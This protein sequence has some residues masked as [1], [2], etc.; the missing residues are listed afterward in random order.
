M[1]TTIAL[2]YGNVLARPASGNWFLPADLPRILGLGNMMKM[3]SGA[4][5][6]QGNMEKAKAYLDENH[7]LHTVEEEFA[8]FTRFYRIAFGGV[9]MKGLDNISEALARHAVYS[10]DKAVFYGDAQ[11]GIRA[12][13]ERWRV[14]V[15][16]DTWP[17]L[18]NT[19]KAAGIAPLLDGMVMSC[20][21]GH[22]K[23]DNGK[24]FQSAIEHHGVIPEE[25]LFVDDSAENLAFARALGFHTAQMDRDGEIEASDYPLVHTLAEAAALANAIGTDLEAAP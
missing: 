1:L 4:Q 13:K 22:S 25:T 21:Y 23:R 11:A 12:L 9:G 15:I 5:T 7:L 14:I 8:Q 24:L 2:D 16:S 20:D 17:S 10:E 6:L 19:L 3:M 18:T